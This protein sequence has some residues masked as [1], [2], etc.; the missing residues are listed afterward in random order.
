LTDQSHLVEVAITDKNGVRK[1][2]RMR[3]DMASKVHAAEMEARKAKRKTSG[4]PPTHHKVVKEPY[5]SVVHPHKGHDRPGSNYHPVP[6][7]WEINKALNATF[8]EK[9]RMAQNLDVARE[10]LE[11]LARSVNPEIRNFITT[12]KIASRKALQNVVDFETA[13]FRRMNK[14]DREYRD[15]NLLNVALHPKSSLSTAADV[16]AFKKNNVDGRSVAEKRLRG[17]DYIPE[18][19]LNQK[20]TRSFETAFWWE[21]NT[22][23]S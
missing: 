19:S 10:Y 7:S 22:D 18:T 12:N 9:A 23:N 13:R 6:M 11:A 3:P 2:V 8:E 14:R 5:K 1:I 16:A 15:E 17:E 20:V 4:V 21:P